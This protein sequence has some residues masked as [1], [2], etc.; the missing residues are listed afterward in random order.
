MDT[1]LV[2]GK[3]GN[4]GGEVLA[5][6]QSSLQTFL[7]DL[8]GKDAEQAISR[9][10]T[11]QKVFVSTFGKD[12]SVFVSAPGRVEIGGNQY[13]EEKFMQPGAGLGIKLFVES[14]DTAKS[15]NRIAG[16]CI[17]PGLQ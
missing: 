6:E 3:P 5:E 7:K 10:T 16:E 9:Y 15:R 14:N 8:Y 17:I 2:T 11:L 12:P 4:P 13:F 1:P